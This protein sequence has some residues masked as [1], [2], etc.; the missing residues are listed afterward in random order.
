MLRIMMHED[1]DE[2]DVLSFCEIEMINKAAPPLNGVGTKQQPFQIDSDSSFDGADQKINSNWTNTS[3]RAVVK[4][5]PTKQSKRASAEGKGEDDC[6]EEK[7]SRSAPE[8]A[9][10]S[11]ASKVALFY[12]ND[13]DFLDSEVSTSASS[14]GGW[15]SK[16]GARNQM[17]AADGSPLQPKHIRSSNE[18]AYDGSSKR[19]SPTSHLEASSSSSSQQLVPKRRRIE[20]KVSISSFSQWSKSHSSKMINRRKLS[21]GKQLLTAGVLL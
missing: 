20:P 21:K 14:T 1:D 16:K 13:E 7:S 9:S 2:D 4:K 12:E 19:K 5:Q 11:S 3:R 10:S 6:E 8:P 17:K 18:E 15:L